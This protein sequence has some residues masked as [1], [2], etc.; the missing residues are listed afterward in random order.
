MGPGE[1]PGPYPAQVEVLT[2]ELGLARPLYVQ[3][4]DRL[5]QAVTGDFGSYASRI[6]VGELIVPSVGVD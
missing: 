6:P 2:R 4:L 1:Q 5:K 3:N